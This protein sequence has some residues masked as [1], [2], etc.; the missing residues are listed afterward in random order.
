VSKR[1]RRVAQ[2]PEFFTD[3]NLGSEVVPSALEDC[4]LVVH[5]MADQY[6]DSLA[7]IDD[8]SWIE[9]VT[10]AGWVILTKDKRIRRNRAEREAVLNCGA[11]LF[12]LTSGRMTGEQMAERLVS[13]RHRILQRAA[14]SGPFIYIV[15]AD[16]LER[17]VPPSS[18]HV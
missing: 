13:N 6:G 12:C 10:A 14:Q 15:H 3:R 9:E 2:P 7:E 8:I 5:R 17:L 11:R 16:R 1:S 4:G 18:Q